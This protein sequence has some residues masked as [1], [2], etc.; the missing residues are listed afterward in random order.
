MPRSR[1][2]PVAARESAARCP[3]DR[4]RAGWHD[5][6]AMCDT[7]VTVLPGRVL[8]AKNSDRDPNEAQVL[9][10]RARADHP[11]GT[12]LKCT[13][14]EIPQ[15]PT[16]HAVLLSRPYWMW[17]AEA[18]ANEYGVAIGNEAVFSRQPYAARGLTGMD[19]VRLGLERGATAE[20]AV[21]EIVELLERYG[22]GGGCGHERRSFTYHNSFLVADPG[23]AFV[24]ETAGR[25][26]QAERITGAWS[27]SNGYTLPG[28]Q[29]EADALRTRVT[30]CATR[31]PR[32]FAAAERAVGTA[33][34][35][36]ALRDHGDGSAPHYRMV[37]GAMAAPCMHAGG[38]LAASQTTASWVSELRRDSSLH[39]VTGTA[40][41]CTALFKPVRVA[42]AL[43]LARPAS[44]RADDRSLWWRHER[45]HRLVMR[46]P[47][48]LR[49]LFEDERD[50]TEARWIADPPDPAMAFAE[51][52]RLLEE[53][54][55]RVA[56]ASAHDGRPWLVRRYWASR[57]ARAALALP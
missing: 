20:Q 34:L 43:D 19:L 7:M 42:E 2:V 17:G 28:M 5:P 32:T 12:A 14:I 37:N 29:V 15:A 31:R 10:W 45:L 24:L 55:A 1:G 11:R 27:I 48:R 49:A 40:A 4:H 56:A 36:R 54:T 52:D 35:M 53:W 8:F 6:S 3:V 50:A 9:D 39:W 26:W 57:N 25:R 41:P 23:G 38:I 30:A 47:A 21:T 44:D 16:T 18:G 33:D 13:W 22:Q 51:G 46:D